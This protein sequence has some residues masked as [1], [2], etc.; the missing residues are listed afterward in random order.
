M[1]WQ[2]RSSATFGVGEQHVIPTVPFCCCAR[3]DQTIRPRSLIDAFGWYD[4]ALLRERKSTPRRE[5]RDLV[6]CFK[7][8]PFSAMSH[9]HHCRCCCSHNYNFNIASHLAPFDIP[10]LS[11]KPYHGFSTPP[12]LHRRHIERRMSQGWETPSAQQHTHLGTTSLARCSFR[13]SR[14]PA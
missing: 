11:P 14:Q 8:L 1:A 3:S 9:V 4:F 13:P 5:E 2:P 10:A 7:L 12:R 6:P